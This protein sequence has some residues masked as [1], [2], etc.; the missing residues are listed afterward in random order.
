MCITKRALM[1]ME[2]HSLSLYANPLH[3]AGV[4]WGGEAVT[5]LHQ[6]WGSFMLG[7]AQA[8]TKIRK[9]CGVLTLPWYGP[10]RHRT[11]FAGVLS[12]TAAGLISGCRK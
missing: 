11:P 10:H 5:A 4:G 9:C 1:K 7:A 3:P 2:M 12:T 8:P 6:S